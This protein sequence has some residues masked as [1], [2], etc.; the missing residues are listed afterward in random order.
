MALKVEFPTDNDSVVVWL[1]EGLHDHA[2]KEADAASALTPS[3]KQY[4][5]DQHR[6]G[7]AAGRI[8]VLLSVRFQVV[9]VLTVLGFSRTRCRTW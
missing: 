3:V 7:V 6:N 4:I 9:V 8:H 1:T 2:V 5:A